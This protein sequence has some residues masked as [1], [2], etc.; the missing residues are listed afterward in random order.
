[1][2]PSARMRGGNSAL[3]P[4]LQL[5][6]RVFEAEEEVFDHRLAAPTMEFRVRRNLCLFKGDRSNL[7]GKRKNCVGENWVHNSLSHLE[8]QLTFIVPESQKRPPALI[9]LRG[10]RCRLAGSGD[11]DIGQRR[12][13]QSLAGL[14]CVFAL[15]IVIKQLTIVF[16]GLGKLAQ[17]ALGFG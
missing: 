2:Q 6:F 12:I 5:L 16:T 17:I 1:M 10:H 13:L 9:S 7:L 4:F 11:T 3:E 15:R 14:F 8:G